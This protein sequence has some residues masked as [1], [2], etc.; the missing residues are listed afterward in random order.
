M[1]K[2]VGGQIIRFFRALNCIFN[3]ILKECPIRVP[4]PA[5]LGKGPRENGHLDLPHTE[6]YRQER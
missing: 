4:S 1:G 2:T 5:F 3:K 6:T